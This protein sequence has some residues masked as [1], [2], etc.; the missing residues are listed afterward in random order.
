MNAYISVT[1]L[2]CIFYR[3]IDFVTIIFLLHVG[4]RFKISIDSKITSLNPVVLNYT[5]ERHMFYVCDCVCTV[6]CTSIIILILLT[7]E[8]KH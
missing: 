6:A 2:L 5:N 4:K 8:G 1:C 7:L 3:R